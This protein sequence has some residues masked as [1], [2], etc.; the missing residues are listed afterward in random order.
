MLNKIKQHGK[1][2]LIAI[3]IVGFLSWYF[4]IY[5]GFQNFAF[6]P[7]TDSLGCTWEPTEAEAEQTGGGSKDVAIIFYAPWCPACK[8]V[9]PTWE[10]LEK[11]LKN[12]PKISLERINGDENKAIL[13][14]YGIAGYPTIYLFRNDDAIEYSGDRSLESLEKFVLGRN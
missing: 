14:K 11:K 1:K 9:M 5:E 3:L 4:K 13:E 7:E 8:A 10:Q 12:H 2:I 6:L